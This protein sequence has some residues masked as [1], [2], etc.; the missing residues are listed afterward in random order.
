MT[1]KEKA[2][3]PLSDFHRLIYL[4]RKYFKPY[5]K[6]TFVL[7]M[8]SFFVAFLTALTP[9]I[10]APILDITLGKGTLFDNRGAGILFTEFKLEKSWCSHALLVEPG[11]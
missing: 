6:S 5:W 4:L 7:I 9:L 10:M 3:I 1:E 2:T 8:T 11:R